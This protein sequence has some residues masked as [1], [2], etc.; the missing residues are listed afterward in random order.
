MVAGVRKGHPMSS[1]TMHTHTDPKSFFKSR[2]DSLLIF[3]GA[4]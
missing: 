4:V 2:R 1:S 3:K